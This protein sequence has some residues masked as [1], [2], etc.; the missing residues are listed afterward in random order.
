[1]GEGTPRGKG[2]FGF[3]GFW[4]SL[5]EVPKRPKSIRVFFV[6]VCSWGVFWAHFG[7]VGGAWN[8]VWTAQA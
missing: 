6:F 1:M 4:D 5:F 8:A 2:F 3:I 7:R